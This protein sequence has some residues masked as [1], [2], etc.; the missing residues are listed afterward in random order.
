MYTCLYTCILVLKP[1]N[2]YAAQAA[3]ET[4]MDNDIRL[5]VTTHY[6]SVP[7]PNP[8]FLPNLQPGSSLDRCA[9]LWIADQSAR[10]CRL[11]VRRAACRTQTDAQTSSASQTFAFFTSTV[12]LRVISNDTRGRHAQVFC[13]GDANERGRGSTFPSAS[14]PDRNEQT[15]R[16][17]AACKVAREFNRARPDPSRRTSCHHVRSS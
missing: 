13:G 5:V 1:T 6:A 10:N 3:M 4:L 16:G 8:T 11:Q 15:A 17:C 9:V 7:A 2:V 12:S 14:G